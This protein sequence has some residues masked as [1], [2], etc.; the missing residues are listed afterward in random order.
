[1][2][3]NGKNKAISNKNKKNKVITKSKKV[4]KILEKIDMYSMMIASA[5][6]RDTIII[7]QDEIDNKELSFGYSTIA[8]REFVTKMFIITEF[9]DYID[10]QLYNLIRQTCGLSGV[11]INFVSN[12]EPY[13]I[14]WESSEMINRMHILK[15]YAEDNADDGGVFDYREKKQ[16]ID[17]SNRIIMST[18][19]LN[20]SELDNNRITLKAWFMIQV[21]ASRDRESIVNMAESIS[22]MRKVLITRG[23][24]IREVRLNMNKWLRAISPFSLIMDNDIVKQIPKKLL[25]DDNIA[26]FS[27][28]KQGKVGEIGTPVGMDIASGSVVNYS[29]KE[30]YEEAENVLICGETGSGKSQLIKPWVIYLISDNY[31]GMILDYEGDEYTNIGAY[32]KAG[33]A[34]DVCITE[35]GKADGNYFDPCKLPK[36]TGDRDTD[37]GLKA[38]AINYIRAMYKIMICK[39]D[40]ELTNGQLK[41]LSIAINRMYESV[42]VTDDMRTWHRSE[43]CSIREPY[44]ELKRIVKNKEMYN[45]DEVDNLWESAKEIVTACSIFFEPNEMYGNTFANAV[46]LEEIYEAR[47]N[48]FS[49]GM[50]GVTPSVSEAKILRLKQSCVGYV[51]TLIANNS[52]YNKGRRNFKIW[53]ECQRWFNVEGSREIIINEITG[54]RKRWTINLIVTNDIASLLEG[55]GT[56]LSSIL[57]DNIQSYYIGKIKVKKT[58]DKFCEEFELNHILGDLNRI[59]K[60]T[61]D[62]V[63]K[64]ATVSRISIRSKYAY[65]FCAILPDGTT[66]VI[67]AEL[68]DSVMQ[69]NLYKVA[70]N[71]K[72]VH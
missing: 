22:K 71:N 41:V 55:N 67:K 28:L 45:P 9:P 64:K 44:E 59:A 58:R 37:I 35:L 42:G 40:E 56:S 57:R 48:I 34:S 27:S 66:P 3:M 10:C 46:S 51:S 43:R 18:K 26:N 24:K 13:V 4:S 62:K 72:G 63:D 15:E 16:S 2:S 23:I 25:V 5:L 61:P 19:Y 8:S 12:S 31:D 1:M 29:F 65:A 33:K 68:P 47:L 39:S 60:A 17:S 36:L 6:D 11:R 7:P 50:R 54:G 49:F 38:D 69:S 32:I 52:K 21:T 14:D 53:E 20:E 70:K 30:N